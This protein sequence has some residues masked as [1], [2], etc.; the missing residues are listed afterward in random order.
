MTVKTTTTCG[1]PDSDATIHP[2]LVSKWDEDEEG[3]KQ[4][5][6]SDHVNV[7]TEEF[8]QGSDLARSS[9]YELFKAASRKTAANKFVIKNN[10][11]PKVETADAESFLLSPV[12]DFDIPMPSVL[13]TAL[14]VQANGYAARQYAA[15]NAQTIIKMDKSG[16]PLKYRREKTTQ[17]PVAE[18][19]DV[20]VIFGGSDDDDFKVEAYIDERLEA[21]QEAVCSRRSFQRLRPNMTP[22][23]DVLGA[24]FFFFEDCILVDTAPTIRSCYSTKATCICSRF[25]LI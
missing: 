10:Q 23:S 11:P 15:K 21:A 19:S 14:T 2:T 17:A 22:G 24:C 3:K 6:T 25:D 13:K 7:S 1:L 5:I 18:L 4:T 12:T 20:D 9:Q 8:E 16:S